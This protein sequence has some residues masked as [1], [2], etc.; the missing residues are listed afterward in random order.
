MNYKQSRDDL[1]QWSLTFLATGTDF[2]GD[3]F[4]MD[5]GCGQ[6]NGS[7]VMQVMGSGR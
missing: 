5:Q 6:G 3:N 1:K 7:V 2:V 4:S